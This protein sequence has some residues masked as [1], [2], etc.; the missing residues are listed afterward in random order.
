VLR[1]TVGFDMKHWRLLTSVGSLCLLL[2]T[3]LALG[4]PPA[5]S[6]GVPSTFEITLDELGYEERVLGSPYGSTEYTIRLPEG[7]QFYEGSFF[8]LDFSYAYNDLGTSE[9][10]ALTTLLSD[11]SVAVDGEVQVILPIEQPVLEHVRLRVELPVAAFNN[12]VRRTHNIAVALDSGRICQ[13]P[14]VARL[15]IHSTSYFSLSYEQLPVTADLAL[16]PRPFYQRA[17][18]PDQVRFVLPAQPAELEVAGAVVVAAK[19]GDLA[20]QIAISGTT[21]LALL[22]RLITGE[23]LHEH[24]FVIGRPEANG[25]LLR[26]N[27]AGLLPVP[28][29][30]RQ[31]ALGSV[32]PA[33]VAPGGAVTYTLVLT[34]TTQQDLYSLSLVDTLPAYTQ[35]EA[36]SPSCAG[37]TGGAEVTWSIPAVAAG[38]SL[39]YTLTV[40]LS[41]AAN[42]AASAVVE[43]TV[44]LLD[45]ASRPVNVSTLAATVSAGALSGSD[46][47][48]AVSPDSGYFFV[49]GERAVPENDGIVQELVS[50]WDQ[51]RA[52]LVITG[53]SEE[54][55]YQASQALGGESR[56][57][58]MEGAFALVQAV[59]PPADLAPR[60]QATDLTFA[61]LGYEDEVV[62]SVSEEA[63]YYFYVPV[64]WRLTEDAYLDLRFSHSRLIDYST[65][66]LSVLFNGQPVAT[67]ALSDQTSLDGQLRVGLP[68]SL[69]SPGRAN[70]VAVQTSLRLADECAQV[71]RWLLISSASLLHLDHGQ[72][73]TGFL[74]LGLYPYPFDGQ[75]D[76]ADVLFVLPSEPQVEEW[77]AALRL[78][79]VLGSAAGGPDL[80]PAVTLQD[81]EPPME[82]GDYHLVVI[83]RPSRNAMLAQFNA[84][85]P[86]PFQPGSDEIEQ[87]IDKVV[88]R[89]PPGLSL[90]LVELMPSPWNEGRAFL[91]V[92]GTAAEGVRWAVD[93]LTALRWALDGNLAVVRGDQVNAVDTRAL[94]SS[95]MLAAMATAVP[96][97]TS[98][99]TVTPMPSPTPDLSASERTPAASNHPVWLVPLV[100]IVGLAVIAIFAIAF[101]QARRRRTG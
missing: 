67:I 86:Q 26:L 14:H 48:E 63:S 49:Q 27:Q 71:D 91:A 81:A 16:Y 53:L 3:S 7:W 18:E 47:V 75:S 11:I 23:V 30:E 68:P 28:L 94:M 54:A 60:S 92:T 99:A 66:F 21:D 85:L 33:M 37:A 22:D 58:G 82:L 62:R 12:P 4:V 9:A 35:L 100:G 87:R 2:L 13:V 34:N 55:V 79:V 70:K 78:A 101:R 39:S 32:G 95:G 77:E 56:F 90:G 45:G 73:D 42:A 76:L 83:G 25:I 98:V 52:I 97:M 15:T 74:N 29:R 72:E 84:Q 20:S 40:R 96:E 61:D 93:A 59:R 36:C 43:N 89:L 64:G 17:F 80:A 50:P 65:S 41:E 19:L 8:E 88:F 57:P 1:N 46:L 10:P 6:Q 38:E 51:A 31:L 24:L 69:E 44:T 5:W